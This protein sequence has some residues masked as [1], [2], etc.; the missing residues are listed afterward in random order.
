MSFSP[1]L[2]NYIDSYSRNSKTIAW[3]S[4][5]KI[6]TCVEPKKKPVIYDLHNY[7]NMNPYQILGHMKIH[8][9]F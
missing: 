4:T 2:L 6:T 9:N 8:I 7:R 1:Y 3:Q 5:L